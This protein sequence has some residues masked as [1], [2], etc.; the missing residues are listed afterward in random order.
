MIPRVQ[1][2]LDLKK[3]IDKAPHQLT[4]IGFDASVLEAGYHEINQTIKTYGDRS[5]S[6][7]SDENILTVPGVAKSTKRKWC[8]TV[9]LLTAECLTVFSG[10]SE[11]LRGLRI[12]HRDWHSGRLKEGVHSLKVTRLGCDFEGV[13]DR[14]INDILF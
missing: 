4:E 13:I 9:E 3:A 6:P 11:K 1:T 10:T 8:A 2:A 7:N 5:L 12:N 14:N